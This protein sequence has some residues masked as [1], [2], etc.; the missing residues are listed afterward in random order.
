MGEGSDEADAGAGGGVEEDVEGVVGMLSAGV[1]VDDLS[2][3]E[4]GVGIS[5]TF[6]ED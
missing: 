3:D 2:R 4:D 1:V 6:A 5:W